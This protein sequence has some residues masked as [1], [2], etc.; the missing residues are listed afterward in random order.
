MT[1]YN[2][3]CRIFGLFFLLLI[4]QFWFAPKL[5]AQNFADPT[6]YLVD[7]LDL[8]QLTPV[9]I[10]LLDSALTL[11]HNAESDTAQ[12]KAVNL[13]V[14]RSWNEDVWPKYNNW[15]HKRVKKKL[16][17]NQE[18]PERRV[19]RMIQADALNNIGYFVQNHEGNLDGA[20]EYFYQALK[21][22]LKTGDSVSVA[23]IY[24]NIGT[25]H[26]AKGRILLALDLLHKALKSFEAAGDLHGVAYQWSNLGLLQSEQGNDKKALE[27]HS[28]S[29]KIRQEINDING[30]ATTNINIGFVYTKR[31]NYDTAKV[32]YERGLKLYRQLGH[33]RGMGVVY[34]NLGKVLEKQG[35]DNQAEKYYLQA[36]SIRDSTG[37]KAGTAMTLAN[38][39]NLSTRLGNIQQAR[40]YSE[41]GLNLAKVVGNPKPIMVNAALLAGIY[42][43][44]G[45]FN[46]ALEM[47]NL[48]IAMRDSL[49]N[50]KVVKESARRQAQYEYE[51]KSAEDKTTIAEQ[52]LE[53]SRNRLEISQNR[54]EISQSRYQR[55][56]LVVGL[57]GL[58]FVALLLFQR[59]R[60]TR[61]QHELAEKKKQL[62]LS[63]VIS[64]NKVRRE[65]DQ[66]LLEKLE[67]LRKLDGQKLSTRINQYILEVRQQLG[68]EEKLDYLSGNLQ[69]LHTE[70]DRK[71]KEQ[72]PQL[73]AS[74]I[75][76]CHM[77]R[78]NMS[79]KEI[80]NLK[81]TSEGAIRTARYRIKNKLGLGDKNL[82]DYIKEVI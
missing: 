13:I 15:V 29:L 28:K 2:P 46:R 66:G 24:N 58:I 52:E 72:F 19:L 5:Q 67:N 4:N 65:F 6:H 3:L 21:I 17:S 16:E 55:T 42:K 18:G 78:L 34:N 53:L 62:D 49:A 39:A 12:L 64:D 35:K 50:L 1:C 8:D 41:R 63:L 57:A 71:L 22:R 43:D 60:I 25:I 27:Y 69:E 70:F 82:D 59:L 36:L 14:E 51:K 32:Y 68:F 31:E 81:K 75:E 38:L 40:R 26:K 48:E 9:E 79:I 37:D 73:T 20:L 77:F 30:M 11:Y 44:Q 54:L 80:A 61:I 7:S 33:K 76:I 47:R 56:L 23:R 74:E 45:D 10:Q